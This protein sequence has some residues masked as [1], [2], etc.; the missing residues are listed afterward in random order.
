V[1]EVPIGYEGGPQ[2]DAATEAVLRA[3]VTLSEV[4]AFGA[5]LSPPRSPL[6]IVTQ[7]E[8][9]H[10][11]VLELRSDVYLVYDTT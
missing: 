8:Y 4:L 5:R 3:Q 2:L 9:T 7:D 11:V 1:R 10:D 6:E